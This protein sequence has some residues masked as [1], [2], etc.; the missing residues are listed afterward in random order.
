MRLE[1]DK[2]IAMR[3][4]QKIFLPA[5]SLFAA[6]ILVTSLLGC[7]SQQIPRF[8]VGGRYEE[9]KDQFLRGRGGDMDTAIDA[10]EFVV[11]KDPTYKNSLTYLGRAYYRKG[12]YKDAYEILQRALFVNQEDELAWLAFGVTQLRVGQ[13]DKGLESLKGGITLASRV[14]VDGY[15]NFIYWD[16]R[17]LIRA[18]IRRSAFL[19]TKGA[20]EKDNII[21][22]TDRLLALVDDEDNF[23]KNVYQQNVRPLY[24]Q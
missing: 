24:G 8:G 3:T 20:E 2:A 5:V 14:M 12:R 7:T 22:A 10:L 15:H 19:L 13:V 9:G 21:Q 16:T 23:Q 17:G 1:P 11:S 6:A 18:S 4:A